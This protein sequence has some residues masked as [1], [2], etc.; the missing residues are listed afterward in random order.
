MLDFN[1][2]AFNFTL[3]VFPLLKVANDMFSTRVPT[4]C[5][6]RT[7]GSRSQIDLR[8]LSPL[9]DQFW[10]GLIPSESFNLFPGGILETIVQNGF[11]TISEMSSARNMVRTL[12]SLETSLDNLREQNVRKNISLDNY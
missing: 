4:A 7:E 8:L 5:C 3:F 10:L 11:V 1:D 12:T 2:L 6:S 9:L